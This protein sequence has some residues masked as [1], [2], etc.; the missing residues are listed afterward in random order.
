[1]KFIDEARIHVRSG[2]GGDGRV[3][4]RRERFVPRGGPD[5]GDG[6]RGANVTLVADAHLDTLLDYRYRTMYE[7]PNGAP[8]GSSGKSGAAGEELLLPVPPG[9]R[10]LD[11]DGELVAD[12]IEPG[13]RL[14]IARGG[15][16]GWGNRRFATA[17]RQAPTFANPG[18]D[19][20][21]RWI[22][23]ELQVLADA[24][25]V[26]FPNAGK[27]TLL[28]RISAATPRVADYPFTTTEPILGL[29]RK[30]GCDMVVADLPGLIEGA[31]EGRGLGHRFLRHLAR[32]HMLVFLLPI[33]GEMEPPAAFEALRHE[34]ESYDPDLLCRD[35]LVCFSR[36]D[37]ALSTGID[38]ERLRCWRE[39][40]RKAGAD[41]DALAISGLTGE[42]VPRLLDAMVA[43][44]RPPDED[45]SAREGGSEDAG[46]DPLGPR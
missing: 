36:I 30:Y 4:F 15:R 37:L 31:H 6:G 27:S 44:L 43:R 40:L 41:C 34:L 16:G 26:G 20:E 22:R 45:P 17:T 3:S 19:A 33:D 35:T 11:D 14:E 8:G 24:G 13:A 9:T 2:R 7:A 10:V 42:G 28:R 46:Y 5:G 21:E 39:E 32:T 38:E 1:M 12:L 18:G 25:L 23:L 29:V